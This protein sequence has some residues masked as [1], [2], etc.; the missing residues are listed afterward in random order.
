MTICHQKPRLR[1]KRQKRHRRCFSQ[2]KPVQRTQKGQRRH[3]SRSAACCWVDGFK[4]FIHSYTILPVTMAQEAKKRREA[5]DSSKK[6]QKRVHACSWAQRDASWKHFG[7]NAPSRSRREPLRTGPGQPSQVPWPHA[8]GNRFFFF[9]RAALGKKQARIVFPGL[10]SLSSCIS[11]KSSA[12]MHCD[13]LDAS[14]SHAKRSMLAQKTQVSRDPLGRVH[15]DK[16]K[17]KRCGCEF[18]CLFSFCKTCHVTK[19]HAILEKQGT[20]C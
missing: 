4:N 7:S 14:I 3:G 5:T 10:D 20:S 15:T 2:G 1:D 13:G 11:K 8:V 9:L 6:K 16:M 18:L 17:K 19:V 12:W